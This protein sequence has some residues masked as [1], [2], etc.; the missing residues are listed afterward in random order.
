MSTLHTIRES[1]SPFD[2]PHRRLRS[3]SRSRSRSRSREGQRQRRRITQEEDAHSLDHD[4]SRGPSASPYSSDDVC[5]SRA[6]AYESDDSE[7]LASTP[8]ASASAHTQQSKSQLNQPHTHGRVVSASLSNSG[9]SSDPSI[10]ALLPP[11]SSSVAH[12]PSLSGCRKVTSYT[13]LNTIDEGTYGVV[14]RAVDAATGEQVA[15]KKIKLDAKLC[16][17]GFPITSLREINILL[18]LNHPNVVKLKEIV[19]SGHRSS[20][21]PPKG[22]YMVMD[23]SEHDLKA[24]MNRMTST[25]APDGTTQTA[26]FK[27]FRIP[28]IKCLLKQLL[29]GMAYLHDNWILHRD[30]KTS[31]LLYNNSGVM[32]ICDFGLARRY[33]DPL[34]SYTPL[35]VTLWYRAPE[36]LFGAT[37]YSS[38]IDMWSVGAIFAELILNQPI[39]NGQTEIEQI[40]KIVQVLGTPDLD[41]WPEFGQL[42]FAKTYAP[43]KRTMSRL[44]ELF[45]LQSYTG[46]N[47]LTDTG[48]HL[49]TQLL[50]YNPNKR[51]SAADALRHPYFSESPLP[52]TIALMPTFPASNERQHTDDGAPNSG[53]LKKRR[54]QEMG[55]FYL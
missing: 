29:T 9:V 33:G 47:V 8:A 4:G 27:P 42:E 5:M 53:E 43:K 13:R 24:L 1:D 51:L 34:G 23:Y 32:K 45:P 28:E 40:S 21:R 6:A 48:F 37:K 54:E 39:F 19:T 46:G 10:T 25:I 3:V 14:H 49:L 50:C 16:A 35:V 22:I 17:S 15:L 31:N 36:L 11:S 18:S 20:S 26:Q 7:S 52:Q 12:D 55:G 2:S 44:R 38:A 41:D 30:L